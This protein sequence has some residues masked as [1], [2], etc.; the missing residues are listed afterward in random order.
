VFQVWCFHGRPQRLSSLG[1]ESFFVSCQQFAERYVANTQEGDYLNRKIMNKTPT[2][3]LVFDGGSRGNPGPGYGSYAITRTDTGTQHLERI[4]FHRR[5]TNNE[6]EYETL[7]VA[8]ENLL[9]EDGRLGR[10]PSDCN[11]EIRG[12]SRLVVEQVA[13]RWKAR[14]PRMARYRDK[15]RRLL[16][17][18]GS[19]KLVQ[20]PREK[21]VAVLGH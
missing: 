18:F 12:D 5:M 13:G 15:V 10:S 1:G 2:H 9:A 6:A 7:I 8:L 17:R 21:S 19:S 11:M 3:I 20:Q 14:D 4:D 16:R